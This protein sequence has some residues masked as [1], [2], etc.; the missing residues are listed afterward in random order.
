[1]KSSNAPARTRGSPPGFPLRRGCLGVL[2]GIALTL[3][4][5]VAAMAWTGYAGWLKAPTSDPTKADITITVQEAYFAQVIASAM[6][7]LPSGLATNISLDLKPGGRIAFAAHLESTLIGAVRG[8]MSGTTVLEA[9]NG[10]LA[11]H[12]TDLKALGFALSGLGE[13]LANEMAGK[14]GQAINDQVRQ[15]LGQDIAIMDVSSD[16]RQLII[17]ARWP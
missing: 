14:L 10:D 12:F 17:R 4:L 1:M 6:P 5:L 11:I 16:D 3:G 13:T 2:A 9:K 7:A 15:G 8:D